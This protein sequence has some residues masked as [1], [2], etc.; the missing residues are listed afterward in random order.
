M[1]ASN[2]ASLGQRSKLAAAA[3]VC[4]TAAFLAASAQ[5]KPTSTANAREAALQNDL[6]ALVA[7]G[8]PGAILFV[9]DG[10]RTVQLTSG[11]GN[12][13]QA[14]PIR[15]ATTSRSRA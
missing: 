4:V 3:I 11:L 12:V 9:R 7:A 5:A 14:T 1:S 15:P 2:H 10:Q 6:D 13:A 8:A